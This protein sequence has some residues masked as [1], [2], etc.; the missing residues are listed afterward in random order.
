MFMLPSA[1]ALPGDRIVFG[2]QCGNPPENIK[3]PFQR[4]GDFEERRCAS[5]PGCDSARRL[6]PKRRPRFARRITLLRTIILD[7]FQLSAF[8]HRGQTQNCEIVR[9]MSVLPRIPD[10]YLLLR[11]ERPNRGKV[12]NDAMGGKSKSA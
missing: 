6:P 11:Q 2:L 8:L 9:L 12:A 4:Y 5:R 1:R 7:A 10:L 3:M